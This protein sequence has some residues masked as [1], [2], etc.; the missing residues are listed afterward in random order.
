MK[1]NVEKLPKSAVK[2][3]VIVENDKVK[4][5]Y[6]HVLEEAVKQTEVPGFRKG[7][8]PKTMVEEKIGVS[9]L[10]GDVL[11]NLLQTYYPQAIKEKSIDPVS[12]PKVELKD[13]DIE[14]DLTFVATVATRPTVK[15]KDYK[16]ELKKSF[17]KKY[18]EAEKALKEES[19]D[20]PEEE[21]VKEPHVHYT[22]DDVLKV[23]LDQ[24]DVEVADVLVE[25]EVANAMQKLLG[26]IQAIGLTLDQYAKSQNKTEEDIKKEYEKISTDNLKLEFVMA[27]VLKDENIEVTDEE[28]NAMIGAVGDDASR[29]ELEKDPMQK[30]YVKS[31]LQ[32]NKLISKLIEYAEGEHH[33]E[34]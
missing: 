29:Q 11:N 16:K 3:T 19:K 17:E 32:K 7:T 12:N 13:F 10:Y 20:K 24:S 34:H 4:K 25:E 31:I 5:A 21:Q 8:A 26:H 27:H 18:K 28:V 9:N 30:F 6:D 33:H 14:K 1:V 2:L 22:A 23:L 15:M